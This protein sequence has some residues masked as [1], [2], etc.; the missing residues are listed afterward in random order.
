MITITKVGDVVSIEHDGV[1]DEVDHNDHPQFQRSADGLTVNFFKIAGRDI[2]NTQP[3]TNF[4]I[5]GVVPTTAAEWKTQL[6]TVFLSAGGAAS[7]TL[8]ILVA[9]NDTQWILSITNTGALVTE[10]LVNTVGASALTSLTL[11]A[12]DNA[13]WTVS[14]N[15]S[16]AL[17]TTVV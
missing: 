6:A 17:V 3:I 15:N 12:P 16:G 10:Q 4:T 7:P 1:I 13:K 14:V 5:S 2:C 9:P 11:T 8:P